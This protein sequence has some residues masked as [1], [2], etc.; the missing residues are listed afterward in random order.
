MFP[1]WMCNRTSCLHMKVFQRFGL[2]TRQWKPFDLLHWLHAPV[3]PTLSRGRRFFVNVVHH[4]WLKEVE[5]RTL[6]TLENILQTHDRVKH[7][8]IFVQGAKT[9]KFQ[10]LWEAFANYTRG[11]HS[12]VSPHL[13][14]WS[15]ANVSQ[16]AQSGRVSNSIAL[17]VSALIGALWV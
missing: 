9:Y 15:H 11:V 5:C 7:Q 13:C 16:K 12:N 14:L 1:W 3:K 8:V 4:V 17:R 6:S 10:T 2:W